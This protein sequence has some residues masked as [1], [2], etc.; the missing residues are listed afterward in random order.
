MTI[1]N[2]LATMTVIALSLTLAVGL[3]LA[4][5]RAV[6]EAAYHASVN[7]DD[8]RAVELYTQAITTSKLTQR[9]L[10]SAYFNRGL[11]YRKLG[12]YKSA[13][14]DYSAAIEVKPDYVAAINNR[15]YLHLLMGDNVGALRDLSQALALR[16]DNP[17]AL[18]GS[19]VAYSRLGM[20]DMAA[21]E[22]GRAVNANRT[23]ADAYAHYAWLLATCPVDK[24]RD[25][26]RAL[27]MAKKAVFI[28]RTAMNLDA[29]AAAYAETGDYKRAIKT[30][31]QAM[32]VLKRTALTQYFH[33]FADR[34]EVYQT[35]RPWREPNH[36][37]F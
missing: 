10:A 36:Q 2:F 6:Y 4:N 28:K 8:Q 18:T 20:Y 1:R 7:G 27:E 3:A 37:Q 32:L 12:M 9:N 25:G 14:A 11:A 23:Y 22:L 13:L 33:D 15:G 29:L 21:V 24:Y 35:N 34:L 16:P 26:A 19:G 31:Q 17:L 5:S 30:Q